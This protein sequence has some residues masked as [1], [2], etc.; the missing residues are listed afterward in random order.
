VKE[1][2][3]KKV[4]S[5]VLK[6]KPATTRIVGLVR[7]K[8]S[9]RATKKALSAVS[10]KPLKFRGTLAEMEIFVDAIRAGRAASSS[11]PTFTLSQIARLFGETYGGDFDPALTIAI[12]AL[13]DVRRTVRV[14]IEAMPYADAAPIDPVRELLEQVWARAETGCEVLNSCR[15]RAL[16][17]NGGAS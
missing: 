15:V 4:Q 16:Q 1:N 14:C 5:K 3:V 10:E 6:R 17:T 12:N 7:G 2:D 11:E 8:R 13:D 9:Q